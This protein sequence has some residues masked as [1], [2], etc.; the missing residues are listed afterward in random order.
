V[1][2]ARLG[3]PPAFARQLE[4]LP[5]SNLC[6]RWRDRKARW[7]RDHAGAPPL[8]TCRYHVE[9]IS[10][11]AAAAWLAQ[12]HYL[13]T[14]AGRQWLFGLLD[15]RAVDPELALVG[16]AVFGPGMPNVLPALFPGRRPNEDSTE[17]LR[18][19]RLDAV[20]AN[21]ESWFLASVFRQ[22]AREGVAAVVSFSDPVLRRRADGQLVAPGHIGTC[23]A[24]ANAVYTGRTAPV[25]YRMFPDD[26]GLL[27]PRMLAKYRAGAPNAGAV[28]RA[29]VA[30]GA[31]PRVRREDRASYLDRLLPQ[32]TVSF[33]HAGLHRYAFA[34]GPH[35][36]AVRIA[37]PVLPYPGRIAS[38]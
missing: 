18:F 36:R 29:L 30:H 11:T 37:R 20:P 3:S 9:P 25:A 21:G 17:L 5:N 35:A 7:Y 6:Q 13:R 33:H 2:Q 14:L 26:A 24:A 8:D 10:Q 31:P 27:H 34:I 4:L 38:G 19:G 12:H 32:L 16:I 23:Y 28:E 1:S 15:D 22:L